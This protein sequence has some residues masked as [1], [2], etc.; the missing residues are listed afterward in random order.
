MS[1]LFKHIAGSIVLLLFWMISFHV[2]SQEISHSRIFNFW[3]K[4][5][6]ECTKETLVY[7][8][9]DWFKEG[10]LPSKEGIRFRRFGKYENIRA[11]TQ[12]S[13]TDCK[14]SETAR[15]RWKKTRGNCYLIIQRK[16]NDPVIY[17]VLELSKDRMELQ[18]NTR[19]TDS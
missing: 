10:E 17:K 19:Q 2:H 18:S 7:R 4:S 13:F 5:Q 15:F 14:P 16:N 1:A 9:H 8:P 6:N 3:I 11:V 12:C